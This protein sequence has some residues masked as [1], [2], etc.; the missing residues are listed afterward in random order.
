MIRTAT[1]KDAPEMDRLNR[2]VLPENYPLEFWES[3]I[4]TPSS[5]NFVI[6]DSGEM[7][8]YV[9]AAVQYNKQ[10]RLTGHV[11]SIGVH[12]EHTRKGYGSQ[13]LKAFENKIVEEWKVRT[14]TLHVRKTNK[15]AI[16]FYHKN[17]YTRKKKVKDYYGKGSDGFLM[18]KIL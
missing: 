11:Y 16:F 9:L 17:G 7:I 10:R 5:F 15:N 4:N 13:L 8:A 2:L 18:E 14:A 6:E 1:V 12:P 3:I